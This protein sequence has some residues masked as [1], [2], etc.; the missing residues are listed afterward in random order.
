MV[1]AR[2]ARRA[3][4]LLAA[5]AA[6]LVPRPAAALPTPKQVVLVAMPE[7]EARAFFAGRPAQLGL[8]V[9]PESRDPI[10]FVR[11]IGYGAP[12][13]GTISSGEEPVARLGDVLAGGGV[14]VGGYGGPSR[15]GRELSRAVQP[16]RPVSAPDAPTG[17]L[18][19]GWFDRAFVAE[20][21]LAGSP[22]SVD[23]VVLGVGARTPLLV[24]ICRS[25]CRGESSRVLTGGIARRPAIVT[26][27]DVGVTLARL[28]GVSPPSERFI[29][30]KLGSDPSPDAL[31]RV[32]SLERRLVRDA[33]VG[34]SAAA[35]IVVLTIAMLIV[36]FLLLQAGRRDLA[37][38]AAQASWSTSAIGSMV[39]AFVP[40]GRGEVRVIA[41]VAAL[42]LGAAFPPRL[43]ARTYRVFFG[44]AVA[45]ALLFAVAPMNP[46]GEPGISLWGNPLVSWRFFGFQNVQ[47][48]LVA[49]GVVVWGMLSGLGAG[50]LV[51]VAIPT[52]LVIAAPTIGANYVGVLTF[53][54]G[55]SLAALALRR[56]AVRLLHIVAAGV[57]ACGAFLLAL[58]AD[59]GSP[60]SHG[61]R[62]AKRISEGGISAA[63]EFV[64]GRLRLNVHLVRGFFGGAILLAMMLIAAALLIRWSVRVGEGP[65]SARVAV[66]A[67]AAMGLT[68]LVLEDSGFYSGAPILCAAGVAWLMTAAVLKESPGVPPPPGGG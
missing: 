50:A 58:L 16:S 30:K 61:G 28:L 27:Y 51:G 18:L 1:S 60:V 9:F 48:A 4:A 3:T 22:S 29:G 14:S 46:G 52:A 2:A 62:A 54:F 13:G 23:I 33:S 6:V 21:L 8:G 7:A 31:A 37:V 47:A 56:R 45:T 39:Y 10:R 67:G 66:W 20:K 25:P 57:V 64:W 32:S 44:V 53:S 41:V 38:R 12:H 43:S 19:V 17:I 26:P 49:S 24:G 55:A 63:W 15:V 65:V 11:E 59:V 68:S 5:A 36:S 34:A 35:T 42:V 40:S